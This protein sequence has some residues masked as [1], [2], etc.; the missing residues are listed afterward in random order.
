I[1]KHEVFIFFG[2]LPTCQKFSFSSYC[3]FA[4]KKSTL[5]ANGNSANC[6]KSKFSRNAKF[7]AN[8]GKICK[9]PE[10]QISAQEHRDS[11]LVATISNFRV[12]LRVF[13]LGQFDFR[14]LRSLSTASSSQN[15]NKN[16]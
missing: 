1:G 12:T 16:N 11:Q 7:P 4:G 9:L 6:R 15:N 2:K 8:F 14:S 5:P 3:R 10:L 13:F